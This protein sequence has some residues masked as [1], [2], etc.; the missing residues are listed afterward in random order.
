MDALEL[1]K[2][3]TPL[4]PQDDRRSRIEEPPPVRLVAVEDCVLPAVAGW[5]RDLDSFYTGLLGFA[6]DL[7]AGGDEIVYRAE[8]FRLRFYVLE[9][10]LPRE[11]YRPVAIVVPSLAALVQKLDDAKIGFVRQRGLEL[12]SDSLLLSDPIGNPV[13]ISEARI[14]L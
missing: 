14:I 1:E 3:T 8:N 10:K 9:R 11:S 12:G 6:R 7:K 2:S 4:E 5:E 13:E